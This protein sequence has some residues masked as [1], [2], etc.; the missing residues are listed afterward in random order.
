[1]NK[2]PQHIQDG[3]DEL[4]FV[5]SSLDRMLR[6]QNIIASGLHSSVEE[7]NEVTYSVLE[8]LKHA[9]RRHREHLFNSWSKVPEDV[10]FPM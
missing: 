1:M 9:C 5:E 3:I 6:I 2:L 7:G 4:K 8:K 10:T